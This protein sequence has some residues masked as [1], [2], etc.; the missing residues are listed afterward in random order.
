MKLASMIA[1]LALM[2][3]TSVFATQEMPEKCPSVSALKT[4]AFDR[5]SVLPDAG[6]WL[7]I[8]AIDNKYD[9]E[10]DWSFIVSVSRD[11][12]QSTDAAYKLAKKSVESLSFVKGPEF[13]DGINA[14]GCTYTTAEPDV[15]IFTVTNLDIFGGKK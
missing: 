15:R 4:A 6:Q 9:T 8:G 11:N 13:F 14:Y 12:A 1:P 5:I 2:L 3:T 10:T 7:V